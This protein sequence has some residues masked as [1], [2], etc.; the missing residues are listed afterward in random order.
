MN[1]DNLEGAPGAAA[2]IVRTVLDYAATPWRFFALVFLGIVTFGGIMAYVE[3]GDIAAYVLKSLGTP[4]LDT[5][6]AERILTRTVR[7]SQAQGGGIWSVDIANNLQTLVASANFTNVPTAPV[8]VG[9]TYPLIS[10]G[11]SIKAAAALMNGQSICYDPAESNEVPMKEL[12]KRGAKWL[13][14]TSIPNGLGAFVGL[15]HIV[16]FEKPDPY[17]EQACLRAMAEA[18]SELTIR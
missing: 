5:A 11:S 16:Y 18:A 6:S 15:I 8:D 7:Q 10:T 1:D 3:R 4:K 12:A 14:A 9:Y 17:V 13:C 2:S